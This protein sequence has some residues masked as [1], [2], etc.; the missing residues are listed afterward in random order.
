MRRQFVPQIAAR[1]Q[2]AIKRRL[3]QMRDFADQLVDLLLLANNDL[4]QVIK[5]IFLETGLDLQ[6]GQSLRVAIC[7]FHTA[8]CQVICCTDNRA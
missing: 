8:F 7:V 6:I 5:Q 1:A 3:P 2:A 4:V